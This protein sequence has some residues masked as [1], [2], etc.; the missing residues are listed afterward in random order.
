MRFAR[1][2]LAIAAL[3]FAAWVGWLGYQA[4]SRGRDYP[5]LSH[6]QVLVSTLD[7]IADVKA[8]ADGTADPVVTVREV[9]W[10]AGSPD[11]VGEPVT[12]TNLPSVPP[13]LGY[14]AP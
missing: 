2:R 9:H 11:W 5:I 8:T 14:R 1:A 12:V 4:W 7:V 10:P 3:A 13:S 6:S